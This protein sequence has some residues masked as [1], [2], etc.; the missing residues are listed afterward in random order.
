MLNKLSQ[1]SGVNH[2]PSLFCLTAHSTRAEGA[3]SS[4]CGVDVDLRGEL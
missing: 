2:G 4:M 1:L 3:A